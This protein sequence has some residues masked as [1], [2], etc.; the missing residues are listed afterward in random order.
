VH[1]PFPVARRWP[2]RGRLSTL[3]A[4]SVLASVLAAGAGAATAAPV[5]A[6]TTPPWY[7]VELYYLKLVNCTRT[8]GWVRANGTC[9]GYGSGRYSKYV[10]PLSLR[11]GIS[12]VSRSWAK[13]LAV[14][15]TCTHGDPGARLR[16]AGYTNWN[17]GENIGCGQ[18]TSDVYASVL[19]SHLA[20]QREKATGGGHWRNIKNATFH[21]VGIG[22]WKSN[23][24]VRVVTDFLG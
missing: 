8:G 7:N 19:A 22:I 5:A 14:A 6:A 12:T 13:H 9:D 4:A 2:A 16:A 1:T 24:H 17:W 10:A 3:L 20:M 23:G 15:N 21:R 18:G 11:A